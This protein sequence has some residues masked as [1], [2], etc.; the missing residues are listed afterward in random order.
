MAPAPLS[1]NPEVENRIAFH[2]KSLDAQNIST[3]PT[4]GTKNRWI[5][6]HQNFGNRKTFVF[7]LSGGHHLAGTQWP[8]AC[9][10]FSRSFCTDG[11]HGPMAG[12][13]APAKRT[14]LLE[15]RLSSGLPQRESFFGVF[16]VRWLEVEL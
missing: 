5:F 9:G 13:R 14:L 3:Y 16:L 7:R 10:M 1:Q 15:R 11:Q 8:A 4:V 12:W 6:V 2:L